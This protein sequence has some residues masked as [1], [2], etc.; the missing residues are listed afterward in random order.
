MRIVLEYHVLYISLICT[1]WIA[2]LL[3]I[4]AFLG[5]KIH[6]IF[7]SI[8]WLIVLSRLIL[9]LSVVV[10][11]ERLRGLGTLYEYM[12]NLSVS[13]YMWIWAAGACITATVFVVRYIICGRFLREALPIQNVP[14]ID[15]E[16]FTFMGI[17]V[18]VSDRISS[19][20]TFGIFRQKVL[21]PAYYMRLSRE[22]LKYILIH[23]KIHINYHD[24][25]NK[26]LVILAVCIHWF[27]PFAW[28]MYLCYNRDIELACDEKVIRQVGESGREDYAN[29][30]I[31]LASR[32][33]IGET[34]YS[35]FVGSAIKERIV[36]IMKYRAMKGWNYVLYALAALMLMLIFA[37]PVEVE[38]KSQVPPQ[39][40]VAESE[41][42]PVYDSV[43]VSKILE[44]DSSG[45]RANVLVET[46]EGVML[47]FKIH[48]RKE[49]A[50]T[51]GGIFTSYLPEGKTWCAG[52]DEEYDGEVT[53]PEAVTYKGKQY[54]VKS[55]GA[56]TFYH[57]KKVKHIY[58]PDT[59]RE[60]KEK[61]FYQ[62][63]SLKEI[64]L[65]AE[66][67]LMDINPFIGCTSLKAFTMPEARGQ[68][69]VKDG[70]LYT[71]YGR[72]L[73][74]CPQGKS[75]KHM[76]VKHD[77]VQLAAYAFYGTKI[78]KVSLPES[79][80]LVRRGCFKGSKELR[81]VRACQKTRF[82]EDAF[83]GTGQV[84]VERYGE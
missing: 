11:A 29:V 51:S 45:A 10:P 66:L 36:M 33:I 69:Q 62:C 49:F 61:A 39:T 6:R 83:D 72:F 28:L 53:I 9:P 74:I 40:D 77:V 80:A 2:L 55:I 76:K 17:R 7:F 78:E 54:P 42:E 12:G 79:V 37:V 18:Y 44:E 64:R 19:P 47:C 59:V 73:K 71:D 70:I 60:I 56:Y 57:C 48:I 25:L 68:Y 34:M 15:E 4:R 23:E 63:Q 81:S 32:E 43:E 22:Q 14:D 58:M 1:V 24:N 20:I 82:A 3:L 67:E 84:S 65:P 35:G 46:K 31:S 41:P 27:N 13:W 5:T 30:L 26:F 50:A 75:K 52:M 8:S 16:I 21:L 38:E